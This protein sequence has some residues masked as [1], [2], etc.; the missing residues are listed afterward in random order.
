MA[1]KKESVD[2]FVLCDCCFGKAGEVV[3]LSA[4]DAKYG[5]DNGV[6]D[7]NQAAIDNA[8]G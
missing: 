5:V 8:K 4:D 3:N 1:A 7:T 2:A 6:L